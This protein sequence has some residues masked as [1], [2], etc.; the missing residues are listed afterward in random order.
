MKTLKEIGRNPH[1]DWIIILILSSAATA[2]LAIGGISLYNAVTRGDSGDAHVVSNTA[3]ADLDKKAL[4][5]VLERFAQKEELSK[6]AK[7][8][9]AGVGDPSI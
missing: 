2:F 9:Y 3:S 1:I 5:R 4:S 7:S 8:G 6:K